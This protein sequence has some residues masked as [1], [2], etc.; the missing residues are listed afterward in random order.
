MTHMSMLTKK[1]DEMST[2]QVHIVDTINGEICTP[3]INQ[4]YACSWNGNGD[5]QRFNEYINYANNY[6]GQRQGG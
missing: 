6:R 5:N 3:C 4:P 1:I 2:K